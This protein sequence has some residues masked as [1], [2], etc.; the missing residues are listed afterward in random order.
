MDS[1]LFDSCSARS[2]LS[3]VR[4]VHPIF[5]QISAELERRVREAFSSA[6]MVMNLFG[7]LELGV[8]AASATHAHLGRLLGPVE[9]KVVD[10]ETGERMPPGPKP[11]EMRV[12]MGG[13]FSW[14]GYLDRA[15]DTRDYLD[16]EGFAK[17]GDLVRYDSQ[18]RIVYLGRTK[19]AIR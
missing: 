12:R 14:S 1:G 8:F 2:D 3:S 11:G 10:V 5:S 19:N 16:Q 9:V 13:E 18:G 17:T 7:T 15:E 4:V 6:S